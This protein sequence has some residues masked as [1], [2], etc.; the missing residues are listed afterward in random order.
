MVSSMNQDRDKP[1]IAYLEWAILQR[2]NIQRTL[3]VLYDLARRSSLEGGW[4]IK[5]ANSIFIEPYA[6]DHFIAAAFSLWRAVF[7]TDTDRS[8][9]ITRKHQ[10]EF[11]EKLLTTNAIAF[12]DDY[13]LRAWTVRF[14]LEAAKARLVIA[15][16]FI[17]HYLPDRQLPSV[18]PLLRVSGE[19]PSQTR[20]EWEA[21]HR[22]LRILMKVL[23]PQIELSIDE[24]ALPTA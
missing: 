18:E 14:Y 22:A 17:G 11:L 12:A 24:L 3:L 1:D 13:K 6:F 21:L 15:N 9:S 2:S 20:Y 7:L 19:E 10:E 5:E 23:D 4:P 16:G 8:W